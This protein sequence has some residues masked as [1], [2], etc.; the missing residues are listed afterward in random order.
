MSKGA[1]SLIF[2]SPARH[3]ALSNFHLLGW[4]LARRVNIAS[5]RLLLVATGCTGIV[6]M[7]VD[8]S[9]YHFL[10]FS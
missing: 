4:V 3:I 10:V 7:G 1:A 5:E 2:S 8:T 9:V 6:G